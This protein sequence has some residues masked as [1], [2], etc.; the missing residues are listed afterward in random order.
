MESPHAESGNLAINQEPKITGGTFSNMST[1]VQAQPAHR[2]R[3]PRWRSFVRLEG[4]HRGP[5]RHTGTPR[6]AARPL[7]RRTLL[8]SFA[9]FGMF[10]LGASSL[11]SLS[12]EKKFSDTFPHL[13]KSLNALKLNEII[14]TLYV[15]IPHS[16]HF[17]CEDTASNTA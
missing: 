3:A 15:L 8:G 4:R 12:F 6:V 7:A 14:W 16:A 1:R 10:S 11:F 2:F 9:C 17:R 5:P 13:Y